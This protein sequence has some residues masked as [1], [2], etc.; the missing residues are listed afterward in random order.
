MV[1]LVGVWDN[2][3]VAK[4]S[5][6]AIKPVNLKSEEAAALPASAVVA[7]IVVQKWVQYGDRV[8]VLGATGGVGSHVVQLLKGAGACFV[9][10]TTCIA[11]RLESKD[12]DRMINYTKENW[13]EIAEFQNDKFDL[14]LDFAAFPDAWKNCRAVLKSGKHGGRFITTAGDSPS[15]SVLNVC[16]VLTLMK[17]IYWRGTWTS[18]IT[19]APKY[20]WFLGG[21]ADPIT[22]ATWAALFQA[23]DEGRLQV[24]IDPAGPFPFTEQGVKDAFRLQESRHAHGKVVIMVDDTA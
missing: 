13:W 14:I 18:C 11:E 9:A 6:A 5:L 24:K 16:D 7:I 22:D 8:L 20:S 21:L 23:I 3:Y 12:I 1:R 2:T 19:S 17:K 4:T 10:A 15:F